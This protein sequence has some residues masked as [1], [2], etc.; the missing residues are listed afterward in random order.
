VHCTGSSGTQAGLLAGFTALGART[1]VIGIA[2]ETN[3]KTNGHGY[4]GWRTP[5]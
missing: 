5:P 2:D 3:G 4:G 1:R